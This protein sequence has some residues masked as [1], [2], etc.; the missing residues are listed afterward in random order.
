MM[1]GV[2]TKIPA[3]HVAKTGKVFFGHGI[4]FSSLRIC[5]IIQIKFLVDEIFCNSPGPSSRGREAFGRGDPVI[6]F[7]RIGGFISIARKQGWNVFESIQ[8][9]VRGC[10]SMR[11]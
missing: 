5:L 8:Q 10:T 4:R 2:C 7:A 1:H 11:A 9:V 6:T 3:V